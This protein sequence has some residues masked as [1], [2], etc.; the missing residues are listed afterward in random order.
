MVVIII[1]MLL[2]QNHSSR[3]AAWTKTFS[4]ECRELQAKGY[5]GD[6]LW[7]AGRRLSDAE[8]FQGS[9]DLGGTA[10]PSSLCG[11]AWKRGKGKGRVAGG[12][13]K[14]AGGRAGTVAPGTTRKK[15]TPSLHTGAQTARNTELT[16]GKRR[17]YVALPGAGS[18]VDGRDYL[19]KATAK[20]QDYKLDE[21]ST[22]RRRA[23]TNAARDLRAAATL[24][25]ITALQA[26]AGGTKDEKGDEKKQLDSNIQGDSTDLKTGGSS[27]LPS[28]GP[29]NQ[30]S[31]HEAISDDLPDENAQEESET[32]DEQEEEDDDDGVLYDSATDDEAD[33][34]A[35][36]CGSARSPSAGDNDSKPHSRPIPSG[37]SA[38]AVAPSPAATQQQQTVSS[39]ETDTQRQRR[40]ERYRQSLQVERAQNGQQ[41]GRK[42]SG[43]GSGATIGEDE[44][45]QT[46]LKDVQRLGASQRRMDALHRASATQGTARDNETGAASAS[47]PLKSEFSDRNGEDKK[48]KGP[49]LSAPPRSGPSAAAA[50][51]AQKKSSSTWKKGSG[52]VLLGG[53]G[54]TGGG[55]GGRGVSRLLALQSA[56]PAPPAPDSDT[57][58]EDIV[59]T[60]F[61]KAGE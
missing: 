56:A 22:F 47:I 45:W 51:S 21:N 7:S 42:A 60:G 34:S 58:D 46:A 53:G 43:S 25:R 44:E 39:S 30:N 40:M 12:K 59:C 9:S 15:G 14:R 4:Q 49:L 38:A 10:V 2:C 28:L 55:E 50:A 6:G 20:S 17:A 36:A 37:D 18:R 13:R 23:N 61:K 52:G 26:A 48:P 27:R 33:D 54:G 35:F 8:W 5:Y 41:A 3:H 31:D 24:R 32:E 19:P 16:A 29:F 11:G 1:T 57:E